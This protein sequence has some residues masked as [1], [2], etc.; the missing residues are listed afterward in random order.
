MPTKEGTTWT[1]QNAY[2]SDISDD[3]QGQESLTVESFTSGEATFENSIERGVPEGILT[4]S[5]T[6]GGLQH[7]DGKLTYSGRFT[8]LS[9]DAKTHAMLPIEDLVLLDESIETETVID[10]RMGAQSEQ[11]NFKV[12]ISGTLTASY[13]LTVTQTP[14][15]AHDVDGQTYNDVMQT[16]VD[17]DDIRIRFMIPSMDGMSAFITEDEGESFVVSTFYFA[18][19]V[20]LVEA[21]TETKIPFR[22]VGEIVE[23]FIG[24]PMDSEALVAAGA[25]D[26]KPVHSTHHQVLSAQ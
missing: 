20:G 12:V 6:F 5:L 17:I 13:D 24:E 10:E 2:S 21:T 22:L 23:E 26:L 7:D 15:E 4:R 25:P 1:Y 16:V 18:R 14:L 11:K 9:F 8:L 19:D 3:S